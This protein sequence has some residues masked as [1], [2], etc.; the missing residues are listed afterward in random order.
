[1]AQSLA[2]MA[3]GEVPRDL[4]AERPGGA[5]HL[6]PEPIG[7]AFFGKVDLGF[8][9]SERAQQPASPVLIETPERAAKLAE[10]LPSLPRRLGRDQIGPALRGREIELA[11]LEGAPGEFAGLGEA[12]AQRGE[13]LHQSGDDGAAAM[14]VEFGDVLAGEALGRGKEQGQAVI[15]HLAG[16]GVDN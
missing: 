8:Y 9:I 14:E 2:A 5:A 16:R 4:A 6:L 15:D 10:R 12:K 13:R 3:V 11:M 1:M 7:E